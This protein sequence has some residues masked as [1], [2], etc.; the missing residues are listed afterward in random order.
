MSIDLFITGDGLAVCE[1]HLEKYI[2]APSFRAVQCDYDAWFHR[3]GK[4]M[5]CCRCKGAT[6]DRGRSEMDVAFLEADSAEGRRRTAS[7]RALDEEIVRHFEEYI[8]H[9]SYAE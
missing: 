7:G 8:S 4:E 5:S 3:H 2:D 1:A 6:D 9:A